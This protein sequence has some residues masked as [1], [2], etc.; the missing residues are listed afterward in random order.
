MTAEQTAVNT[1]ALMTAAAKLERIGYDGD[2]YR[3]VEGLV[4]SVLAD[5][6]RPLPKPVPLRPTTPA[7]TPAGRAAAR[8]IYEQARADARHDTGA[9]DE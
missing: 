1:R 2:A 6:Y 7:S 4:L 5:G 8:A 3:F 9:N